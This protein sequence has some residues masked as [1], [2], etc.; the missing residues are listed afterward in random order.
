M[1][2]KTCLANQMIRAIKTLRDDPE[3][4]DF[5]FRIAAQDNYFL[6]VADDFLN[7]TGNCNCPKGGE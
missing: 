4:T 7:I 5:E 6:I 2:T 1:H 3:E